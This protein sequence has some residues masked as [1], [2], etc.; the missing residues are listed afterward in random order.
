MELT[1]SY[2]KF[3]YGMKLYRTGQDGNNCDGTG[4]NNGRDGID[5]LKLYILLNFV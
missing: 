4:R 3:Q 1:G 2:L 5:R